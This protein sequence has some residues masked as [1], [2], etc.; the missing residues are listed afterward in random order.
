MV[1]KR[2]LGHPAT[3][4]ELLCLGDWALARG[5]EL[6]IEHDLPIK[7]YTGYYAGH[8]TMPPDRIRAGHLSALLARYPAARVV[9]MH[10]AYPYSDELVALAKH[11]SNAYVDMCWAWSI[12]PL[13]AMHF[14]RRM[15]HAV[16]AHKLFAFGGDARQPSAALAYSLQARQWLTRALQAEVDDGL[17][18][19]REAIALATRVMHSNQQAC[20]D[21]EGTRS[22]I[23]A[24][25][26]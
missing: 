26:R 11:Y 1:R 20:F 17:L 12:D 21:I 22:A 25:M 24:A 7:I 23:R 3:D 4:A 10:M 19:E 2:L 16:P 8:G 6:A 14:L 5:V 9:L 13:S 18:S 15:I